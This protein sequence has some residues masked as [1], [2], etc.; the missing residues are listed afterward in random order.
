MGEVT[1]GRYAPFLAF[2]VLMKHIRILIV[3]TLAFRIRVP[4][5]IRLFRGP[6]GLLKKHAPDHPMASTGAEVDFVVLEVRY[7]GV[8]L[9]VRWYS[10]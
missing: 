10:Q 2:Y 5:P 9:D 7:F 4:P 8:F 1:G 6:H 3:L